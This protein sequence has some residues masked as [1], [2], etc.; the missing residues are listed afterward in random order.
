MPWE[1]SERRELIVLMTESAP[2][3]LRAVEEVIKEL[4]R[5]TSAA[6]ETDGLLPLPTSLSGD[7]VVRHDRRESPRPGTGNEGRLGASTGNEGRT[8]GQHWERG[9]DWGAGTGPAPGGGGSLHSGSRPTLCSEH[10]GKPIA[11]ITLR[12]HTATVGEAMRRAQYTVN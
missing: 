9:P 8:G 4:G 6:G 1:Q 11:V 12:T 3:P 7:L 2:R 10:G 5:S